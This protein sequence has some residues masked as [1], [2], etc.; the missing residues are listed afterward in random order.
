MGLRSCYHPPTDGWGE[1]LDL[2]GEGCRQLQGLGWRDTVKPWK[3][4]REGVGVT[5]TLASQPS[6]HPLMP[7]IHH[8]HP[9]PEARL[10]IWMEEGGAWMWREGQAGDA[11]LGGA[12]KV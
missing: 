11:L 9:E 8:A 6:P 12:G 2:Y 4:G 5:Q 10:P 3:P 7:P 1:G